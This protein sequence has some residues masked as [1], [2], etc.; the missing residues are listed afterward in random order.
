MA[1]DL[2]A[3]VIVVGGGTAGA[4][5]AHRLVRAG[6]HVMVLEA[7]PD[8]GPCG[9]RLW[10]AD[11]L[12]PARV[13]SSHDWGYSGAAADGRVL[14]MARA[15]VL[16]G[17]SA[18]NGCTQSIGWHQDWDELGIPSLTGAQ[19]GRVLPTISRALHI[20]MP[21]PDELSPFQQDML[22]ALAAF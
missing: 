14:P 1:V 8:P 11:L 22:G 5:V 12:D 6:A 4:V 2:A 10:P 18:H 15:R 16:G 13:A 19:V 20:S 9:S 21:D 3:D 17:C 7:G